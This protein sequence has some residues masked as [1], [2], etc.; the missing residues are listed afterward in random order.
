M[1]TILRGV[2]CLSLLIAAGLGAGCVGQSQST[3]ASSANEA[4]GPAPGSAESKIPRCKGLPVPAVD[5]LIDD[6]EDDNNQVAAMA[7]RD[8]YW[9]ISKD[10]LGSTVTNPP[11]GFK[12]AEG[13]A[14]GSAL[15]AHVAGHTVA[16]GDQ[17]WGVEMGGNFLSSKAGLY[18]ASK[19]AGISFKAKAGGNGIKTV[20]VN[21]TDVNTHEDAGV[22]KACWNHFKKD[23]TF[24]SDWKEYRMMFAE[25]QQREGWGDPRPEH[26][27]TNQVMSVT[28][29]VG[30]VDGDFDLWVDDL[31]FLECKK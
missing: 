10:T 7:D 19:Y 11:E 28:F 22:C 21:L 13:G 6:F 24:T 20:R 8:G 5:G 9:W 15:S 1:T 2:A 30:G 3:G 23:F 14:G 12:P 25:L 16:K 29:A 27:A 4:G 17:S 31:Q 18:D 26:V